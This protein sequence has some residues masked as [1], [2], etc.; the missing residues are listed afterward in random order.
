MHLII[1]SEV[2]TAARRVESNEHS[3]TGGQDPVATNYLPANHRT[4]RRSG[5]TQLTHGLPG[6]NDNKAETK[7]DMAPHLWTVWAAVIPGLRH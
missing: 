2:K 3:W 1:M 6:L 7:P 5:D 4:P